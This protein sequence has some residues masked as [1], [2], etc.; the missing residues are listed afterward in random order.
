VGS[1]IRFT[2]RNRVVFPHPLEPTRTVIDPDG[3]VREKSLTASCPPG[4]VLD[5]R[6]YSIISHSL[7]R[8]S[9][10]QGGLSPTV[11]QS[12]QEC[13]THGAQLPENLSQL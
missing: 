6:R 4:K 9:P 10:T 5:T 2:I 7:R 11:N 13:A 8:V 1:T 3:I 12:G